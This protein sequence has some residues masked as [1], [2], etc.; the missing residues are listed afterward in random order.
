MVE[1]LA[2]HNIHTTFI[3]M[4]LL[5]SVNLLLGAYTLRRLHKFVRLNNNNNNDVNND[6]NID[7]NS[8]QQPLLSADA[9]SSQ[10]K[11]TN[12]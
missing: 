10:A 12:N 1:K 11:L 3:V 7:N 4:L 2:H 8:E 9:K 6:N 5:C